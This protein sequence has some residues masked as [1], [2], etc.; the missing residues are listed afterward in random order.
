L[1]SILTH[2]QYLNEKFS[3]NV[4]KYSIAVMIFLG[5]WKYI[6]DNVGGWFPYIFF[7]NNSS[8]ELTNIWQSIGGKM[9]FTSLFFEASVCGL[10]LALF[11][12]NIFCI[13]VRNKLF[14]LM[15]T[16]LCLLLTVAS[17]GFFCLFVGFVI[18][19][20]KKTNVKFILFFVFLG[21]IFYWIAS[22]L[23]L[24]DIVYEMTINK[25]NSQSAEV[26]SEIMMSGLQIFKDTYGWGLGLGASNG[27]G[28][29]LTLLGQTGVL[30]CLLFVIWLLSINRYLKNKN[31][32]M[33]VCL[34]VILMGMC[35]SIGYLSFPAFWLELIIVC[36]MSA[37]EIDEKRAV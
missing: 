10:F 36:C 19:L 8:Y 30:G 26:R 4:V 28:L 6:V 32:K 33:Q 34:W 23:N 12:W 24:F 18:Y 1:V 5:L 13:K 22:Y 25:S 16:L 14:L 20:I 7:F 21:V 27:S 2:H 9:R 3:V 29:A 31:I 11:W 17:T 37:N 15:I 35:M